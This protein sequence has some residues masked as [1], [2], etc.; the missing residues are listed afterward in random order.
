MMAGVPNE[1][2]SS[3]TPRKQKKS[4][5]DAKSEHHEFTDDLIEIITEHSDFTPG[6]EDWAWKQRSLKS[7]WGHDQHAKIISTTNPKLNFNFVVWVTG[8]T[9]RFSPSGTRTHQ[10]EMIIEDPELDNPISD[11]KLIQKHAAD[12]KGGPL[13]DYM[14]QSIS[15]AHALVNNWFNAWD[16]G[17]SAAGRTEVLIDEINA[18]QEKIKL[19]E[20][21]TGFQSPPVSPV[22]R[23]V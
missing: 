9:A 5:R 2:G 6:D 11:F 16:Y 19:I 15:H 17:V 1:G 14:N 10:Y 12:V 4:D 20:E 8:K 18:E 3:L 13:A 22:T 7:G 21:D 23:E